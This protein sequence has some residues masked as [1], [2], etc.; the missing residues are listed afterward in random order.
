MPAAAAAPFPARLWAGRPPSAAAPPALAHHLHGPAVPAA[1][2]AGE[3]AAAQE[4]AGPAI[5]LPGA[6]GRRPSHLCAARK[7]AQ[8]QPFVCR[9]QEGAAA[10]EM[11]LE[12]AACPAAAWA[13]AHLLRAPVHQA[14]VRVPAPGLGCALSS[15]AA[16]PTRATTA[17]C[18]SPVGP[19]HC[20]ATP[21]QLLLF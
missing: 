12:A 3:H 13:P 10:K 19:S 15:R 20:A 17:C 7:R 14:H 11:A 16:L 4:N 8:A 5:C 2:S 21:R 18:R 1:A 6:R 9:A